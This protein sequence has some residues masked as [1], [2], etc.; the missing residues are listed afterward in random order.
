MHLILMHTFICAVV[1]LHFMFLNSCVV[2]VSVKLMQSP[3]LKI[4]DRLQLAVGKTAKLQNC[5]SY[6]MFIYT[7]V[8][9]QRVQLS[10]DL[11]CTIVTLIVI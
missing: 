8:S 2:Y 1:I 11:V 6:T 4:L 9:V 10:I 7:H 3:I 5:H